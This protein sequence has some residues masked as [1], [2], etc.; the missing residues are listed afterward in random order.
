[1]YYGYKGKPF[2]ALPDGSL[3]VTL[4]VLDLTLN[5]FGQITRIQYCGYP[6]LVPLRPADPDDYWVGQ[7]IPHD[8]WTPMPEL[9]DT[10]IDAGL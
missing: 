5:S 2:S 10:Y 3:G 1:M 7:R 9:V 8:A 6:D 4:F